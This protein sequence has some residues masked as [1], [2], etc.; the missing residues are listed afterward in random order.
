MCEKC[1]NTEIFSAPYLPVFGLNTEIY[2]DFD[3]CF[4]IYRYLL[5]QKIRT[6]C[7]N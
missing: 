6:E 2:F 4:L 7:G 1:P 5:E 3:F